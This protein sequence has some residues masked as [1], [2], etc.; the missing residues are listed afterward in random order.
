VRV[1]AVSICVLALWIAVWL[2]GQ[3]FPWLLEKSGAAFTFW[4]FAGFSIINFIFCWKV[5][6]ET[7][8]KTLEEMEQ[9]FLPAH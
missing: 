4:M 8:G 5:V 7:T 2:V 3:F 6:K 9:V 1:K